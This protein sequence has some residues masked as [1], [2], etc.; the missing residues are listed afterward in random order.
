MKLWTITHTQRY[1]INSQYKSDLIFDDNVTHE[2][3]KL[4]S[5]LVP[6]SSSSSGVGDVKYYEVSWHIYFNIY[7]DGDNKNKLGMSIGDLQVHYAYIV[8]FV[9]CGF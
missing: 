9:V 2:P 5:L 3:Y 6:S 8:M 1:S 4:N 7:L